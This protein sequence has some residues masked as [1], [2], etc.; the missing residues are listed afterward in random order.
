MAADI[1]KVDIAPNDVVPEPIEPLT[2]PHDVASFDGSDS[3]TDDE[4]LRLPTEL[5]VE[6]NDF[7]HSI[8]FDGLRIMITVDTRNAL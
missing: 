1:V 2:T 8:L 3:G 7:L 4:P 5:E 6:P